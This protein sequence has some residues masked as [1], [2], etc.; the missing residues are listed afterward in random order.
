MRIEAHRRLLTANNHPK[1]SEKAIAAGVAKFLGVKAGS[2]KLDMHTDGPNNK[3]FKIECRINPKDLGKL[4]GLIQGA[5]LTIECITEFNARRDEWVQAGRIS[6][7][8]ALDFK[9]N[10]RVESLVLDGT[11]D[12]ETG[13]VL[14]SKRFLL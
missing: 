6:A 10:T 12:I 2:T 1:I 11:Y 5:Y 14:K 13:E 3:M 7:N 8:L 4:G 9:N